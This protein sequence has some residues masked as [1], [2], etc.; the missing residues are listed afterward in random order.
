M[1]C[2]SGQSKLSGFLSLPM[3]QEGGDDAAGVVRRAPTELGFEE[4][5]QE[6]GIQAAVDRFERVVAAGLDDL[7]VKTPGGGVV[8][9]FVALDVGRADSRA[10]PEQQSEP[11]SMTPNKHRSVRRRPNIWIGARCE[12]HFHD[13]DITIVGRK[14]KGCPMSWGQLI[15]ICA[16]VYENSDDALVATSA[17]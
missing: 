7:V 11:A 6:A 8:F 14:P 13:H 2:R 16:P 3:G 1:S 9:K 15:Q 10:V 17:C 4:L 12:K 5:G